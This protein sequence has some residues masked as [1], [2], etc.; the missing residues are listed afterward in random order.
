MSVPQMPQHDHMNSKKI[1]LNAKL[2]KPLI[3][4]HIFS[5]MLPNKC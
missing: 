2:G 4:N 3:N 1:W 5:T